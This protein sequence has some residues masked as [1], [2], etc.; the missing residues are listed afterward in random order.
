MD[1]A[2]RLTAMGKKIPKCLGRSIITVFIS[3][4]GEYG[5]GFY[6]KLIYPKGDFKP[7]FRLPLTEEMLPKTPQ[8]ILEMVLYIINKA[9]EK[10]LPFDGG[11]VRW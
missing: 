7:Y 5:I 1:I 9:K 8:E 3:E 6:D 4:G 11:E 10:G 2:T